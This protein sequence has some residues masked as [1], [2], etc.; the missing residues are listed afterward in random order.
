MKQVTKNFLYAKVG[1]IK[2]QFEGMLKARKQ[3][4]VIVW[5]NVAHEHNI[6]YKTSQTFMGQLLFILFFFK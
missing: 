2:N 5:E 1:E 6:W 4:S 3:G